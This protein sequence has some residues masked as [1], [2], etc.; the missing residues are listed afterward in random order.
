MC[1]LS[2]FEKNFTKVGCLNSGG[3]IAVLYQEIR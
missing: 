2:D 1:C 3:V